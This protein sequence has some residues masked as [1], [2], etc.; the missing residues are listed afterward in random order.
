MASKTDNTITIDC[1]RWNFLQRGGLL[2]N[3]SPFTQVRRPG[4]PP[5]M[6]FE[7]DG[8]EHAAKV[9]AAL[10]E[11]RRDRTRGRRPATTPPPTAKTLPIPT[12]GQLFVVTHDELRVLEL[13]GVT[14]PASAEGLADDH[15]LV[16]VD[17]HDI[18]VAHDE[19]TRAR[20]GHGEDARC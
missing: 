10:A 13:A 5:K 19:L 9:H 1:F 18:G 3:Q 4:K 12:E 2:S 15:Y 11:L 16:A 20:N 14:D 17:P 7:L 8:P 6:R